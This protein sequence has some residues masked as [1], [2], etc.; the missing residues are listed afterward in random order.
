VLLSVKF[1]TKIQG[2]LINYQPRIAD[3]LAVIFMLNHDYFRKETLL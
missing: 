1:K 3:I 2:C